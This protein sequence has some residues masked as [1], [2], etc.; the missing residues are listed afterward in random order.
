[1]THP[2]K[3]ALGR[4]MFGSRI[5]PALL[6]GAAVIVTF[7]RVSAETD[8]RGLSITPAMFDRYCRF[9]RRCFR[10]TSLRD[11]V[12][13]I[14]QRRPV[15]GCLAITFDDGYLDNYELAAPVLA[16]YGLPATFFIVS[17][18]IASRVVPWWDRE[19]GARHAWMTWDQVRTLRRWG[20]DI[21]AHTRT[22]VDL[23][24]VTGA[25]ASEEI[26]GART[27]IEAQLGEPVH[28]FAYPYGGA[29]HLAES[30]REL[31][32]ASGF[33]CCCSCHGG[34]APPGIDPFRLRRVA[35]SP[36]YASPEQFGLDLVRDSMAGHASERTRC[37]E[38]SE[39]TGY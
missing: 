18:W 12:A 3:S 38:I 27:E 13:A 36:W 25:A 28:L 33:R 14:E 24:C 10:V 34:V 29:Q 22:H 31:V 23:G 11:V 17:Q 20:F 15:N 8:V 7:H 6:G 39:A 9:F 35:V 37:C 21:G 1:V 2:I 19:D 5:G 16:R 30:N 4:V 26:A 32:K